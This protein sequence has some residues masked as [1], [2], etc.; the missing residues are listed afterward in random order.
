MVAMS[1]KDFLTH[2]TGSC[3]TASEVKAA[4]CAAPMKF[5]HVANDSGAGYLSNVN[6]CNGNTFF[7]LGNYSSHFFLS[8]ATVLFQ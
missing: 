7:W 6:P 1:M 5:A 8:I 4:D 2:A 3:W